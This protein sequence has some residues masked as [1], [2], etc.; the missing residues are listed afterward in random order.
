MAN[1]FETTFESGSVDSPINPNSEGFETASGTATYDSLVVAHGQY[2][3]KLVASAGLSYLQWYAGGYPTGDFWGRHYI[4]IDQAIT[5]ETHVVSFW[6]GA[7]QKAS[8]VFLP[9]GRISLR[10]STLHVDAAISTTVWTFGQWMRLEWKINWS[11]DV[12]EV[13]LYTDPDSTT[14]AVHLVFPSA[15]GI[16]K[17]HRIRWGMSYTGVADSY[18]TH[19]D[20][21]ALSQD[22]AIGASPPDPV[23][24][25]TLTH[26]WTGGVTATGA[27]IKLKMAHA[28]TVQ[29]LYAIDPGSG[30]PLTGTPLRSPSAA[31]D[32][33]GMVTFT[34]D[35]LAENT[36]YVYGVVANETL[37]SDRAHF[38]TMARGAA[39]FSVAFSSSQADASDHLIFD[40]IRAK[41]PRI[42]F[43]LGGLYATPV[44]VN[45]AATVRA[46]YD[47]Q[48]QAGTKRF[49]NLLSAVPVDYVWN[50]TDWG[51]PSG[52]Q[53]NPAAAALQSVYDQY[54]PTYDLP[55]PN[56]AL[57]HSVAIGRVLFLVLDVRS[58]RG[59]ESLLGL[60][61][62]QWLKDQLITPTYPLKII[63]CPL[64]WRSSSDWGSF[65]DEFAEI[66]AYITDNNLVNVMM[67][68]AAHALAADSGAN[69]GV[70]RPNVIA[71]ALDA[72][73]AAAAGTW[74]QDNHAN[75]A[76]AG[77]YGLLTVT[78]SG[79]ATITCTFSGWN[80]VGVQLTGP[81]AVVFTLSTH[82]TQVKM[83]DGSDWVLITPRVE[84]ASGW[85]IPAVRVWDSTAWR[86]I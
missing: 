29:L 11:T 7:L 71:G 4:H 10:N 38:T 62:K 48:I 80:Q 51:G 57:Y 39:D 61:Q 41:D 73:G 50:D 12:F 33:N 56:S 22:G 5:V 79:G 60:D 37:L 20:N 35:V 55:D 78:D 34:L 75:A 59:T 31:P 77:Q 64:P 67:L 58:R 52:N 81:Y 65:A 63:V 8:I 44:A 27:Q 23:I 47:A 86:T 83:W 45:D 76:G 3:A 2:A 68:G 9:D 32:P 82:Q 15:N 6:D 70:N 43:H 53:T 16:P 66:N 46:R 36:K 18:A 54:V 14:E 72:T 40:A 1:L 30:D 69:S 84:L 26:T 19:V 24:P 42:F 28:S 17:W 21:I 49:K 13:W 85:K 25:A 74:D